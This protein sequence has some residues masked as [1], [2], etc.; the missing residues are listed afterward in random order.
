MIHNFDYKTIWDAFTN[1]ASPVVAEGAF[2]SVRTSLD[3]GHRVK[4]IME[5]GKK[6]LEFAKREDFDQWV[7][8]LKSKF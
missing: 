3:E 1:A 2:D 7:Q 4:I 8:E 6:P 5:E